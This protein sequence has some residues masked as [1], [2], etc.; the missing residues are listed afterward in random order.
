MRSPRAVHESRFLIQARPKTSAGMLACH[1][2]N[3][4]NYSL[5]FRN[6]NI[7]ERWAC[8]IICGGNANDKY[9]AYI[10]DACYNNPALVINRV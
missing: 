10:V 4:A 8:Q 5:I 2:V 6:Y 1:A 9:F 7:M 3:R